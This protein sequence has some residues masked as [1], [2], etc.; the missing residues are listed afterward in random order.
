MASY[1][2]LISSLPTLKADAPMPFSY[3]EFLAMCANAVSKDVFRRLSELTLYSDEGPL[4]KQWGTFYNNLMNS[5]N[6]QRAQQLGKPFNGSADK[7]DFTDKAVDSAMSAKNPLEA[8][9]I[10]L[11]CQ[12]DYL[13]SLVAM[14]N[15]DDYVLFGY[16]VKLKLLERQSV[17]DKAAGKEEFEKLSEGIEKLILNI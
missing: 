15:F 7:D 13:D 17:F 14:H 8:E 4:L 10:L 3:D 16:A 5:L 1:Y 11:S 2:Y 9:R 12:F 6:K